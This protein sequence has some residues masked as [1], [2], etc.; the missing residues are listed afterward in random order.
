MSLLWTLPSAPLFHSIID[1]PLLEEITWTS[2]ME[3]TSS[4]SVWRQVFTFKSRHLKS[5]CNPAALQGYDK[6][7]WVWVLA[8]S[9]ALL[10]TSWFLSF[11]QRQQIITVSLTNVFSQY[12]ASPAFRQTPQMI[13]AFL[14][15]T[16]SS[17]Q[18][19][20]A[21]QVSSLCDVTDASFRLVTSPPVRCWLQLLQIHSVAA[22]TH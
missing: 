7:E 17:V 3:E 21:L 12:C 4:A 22:V 18:K 5:K 13:R 1:Q 10:H 8:W 9:S 16:C 11:T 20:A 14:L 15:L 19:Y 6:P 2:Q